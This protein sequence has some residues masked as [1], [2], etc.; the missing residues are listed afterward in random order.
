[1]RWPRCALRVGPRFFSRLRVRVR[2][3]TYNYWRGRTFFGSCGRQ[4]LA[5]PIY[6]YQCPQC[7]KLFEEWVKTADAQGSEAC[8]TCGAASPRVMS[9]TSFVLKGEGWYVSD[10]GYRKDIKEDGEPSAASCNGDTPI[11]A[12]DAA[13]NAASSAT[14][15]SSGAAPGAASTAGGSTAPSAEKA[16]PPSKSQAKSQGRHEA[17]AK[18]SASA[19]SASQPSKPAAAS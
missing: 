3:A 2:A 12:S 16:A 18:A 19:A 8:P 17:R 13:S 5:M 1:M 7:N 6:E 4:A 10:Y 9:Q 14:D 11:A 15:A